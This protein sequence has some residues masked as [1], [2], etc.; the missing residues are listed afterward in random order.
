MTWYNPLSWLIRYELKQNHEFEAD[1]NVLRQGIDESDYQLLLVKT[2]AGEHRYKLANQF[3]QMS[4]KTRITMMNKTKSRNGAILKALLF[5]PLIALM[6]Q[7]LAQ[8]EIKPAQVSPQKQSHGKY[9]ILTPD[10]LKLLGFEMNPSGLFYKN[11]RSGRPDGNILCMYFTHK[12]FSA[13]MILHPGEKITGHTVTDQILKKQ[14]TTNFDFYPWVVAWINGF[15]TLVN[16]PKPDPTQKLL[17]VQINMADLK[18]LN[19][20]DTLVFWFKPTES[21]AKVLA[22]IVKVDEYLQVCPPDARET[23]VKKG[24]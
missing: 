22:P 17:P 16:T 4:I 12:I 7:V 8:K 10:Q 11:Q 18:M 24:K 3:N 13:S 19:R 14:A 2:A 5:L 15:W 20:T 23:K 1:R 9:L 6:V 21:L